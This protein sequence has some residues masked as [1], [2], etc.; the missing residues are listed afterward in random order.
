M[1]F[2]KM[3]KEHLQEAAIFYTKAF[4]APPWNDHFTEKSSRKRLTLM[5]SDNSADAMVAYDDESHMVGLIL[6]NYEYNDEYLVFQ[7]KEFCVD[8]HKKGQGIGTKLLNTMVQYVKDK[9]VEEIYLLTLRTNATEGYYKR[10]GYVN[11]EEWVMM[12]KKI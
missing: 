1:R 7:I 8:T 4:N 12:K 3:I 9:G 10:L 2:E 6:G 5:L 11:V